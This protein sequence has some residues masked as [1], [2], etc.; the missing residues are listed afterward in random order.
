MR[1]A[2]IVDAVARIADAARRHKVPLLAH[3]GAADDPD[4]ASLGEF[5]VT[6]FIVASDQGMMRQTAIA[7]RKKFGA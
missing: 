5:G 4:V 7:N 1:D 2:V 3:V 6:A